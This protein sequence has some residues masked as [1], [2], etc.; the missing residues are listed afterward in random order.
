MDLPQTLAEEMKKYR[1]MRDHRAALEAQAKRIGEEMEALE[2]Q[3]LSDM[4]AQGITKM[5]TGEELA[6]AYEDVQGKIVD[7][8]ALNE[9]IKE[10][11]AFYLLQRRIAVKAYRELLERGMPPPGIE[12]YKRMKL[13]FSAAKS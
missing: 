5:G 3:I 12:P 6:S 10:N 4:A 2:A 11:N 1:A 13:R 8:D 7:S 9:Y